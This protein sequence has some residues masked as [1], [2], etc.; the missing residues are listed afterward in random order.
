MCG[1][2]GF[3]D[4]TRN[5]RHGGRAYVAR[6]LERIAYRGPDQRSI[7]EYGSIVLGMNRL[8]IVDHEEHSIPYE[9]PMGHGALVYNGEIYNHQEIR[10]GLGEGIEFQTD[11]DAETVLYD[12]LKR[13]FKGLQE[14]NGMYTMA[15]LNRR[16][17]EL[18]LVRDKAGE[19][20]LYYVKTP[21]F[22]AFASEMKCLLDLIHPEPN[23]TLAYRAFE[24]GVGRETLFKGIQQLLPGEMLTLNLEGECRLKDY[25]KLWDRDLEIPDDEKR[26]EE[27]LTALIEDAIL[28]RTRNSV[29][30]FAIF[31]GGGVDSALMA[32]ISKPDRLYYC[33]YD[34]GAAFDELDYARLVAKKID[35]ELVVVE[36][37]KEDFERTRDRIA[38]HL[39]TPC[40]WTSFSL[41]MLL[42]SLD[43]DIRVIM[44]GE[45][46]D[47]AFAGYHRYHLLHHDEQ[48]HSLDAMKEYQYLI[49][50]YYGS[51]EERYVRLINPCDNVYDQEV[52]QYLHEVV[53]GYFENAGGDVVHGMGMND[54]YSTMQVLLQMSDRLSMAF[55][56]ENRSPFLD[57]RLL[58]YAFR[59]PS[60]YKIREGRTKWILKKISRKIIPHEIADRID[61]RGFSAPLNVWFGWEKLGKYNRA[62]YRNLCFQDWCTNFGMTTGGADVLPYMQPGLEALG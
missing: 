18:T 53:R 36:P 28:L 43:K 26:I 10:S 4:L 54:F 42:E 22:F 7:G 38:Y 8:S 40:T 49:Q 52:M 13:G 34:L 25:W 51:P 2:V 46:A 61:K 57:H 3:V 14:Y 20:P 55:S 1:I 44:T 47:E 19:K 41:W 45:G 32:C 23:I 39:D 33:H 29:H 11:S 56:I 5:P 62:T 31:T 30:Q 24:F 48:I 17:K 59:M 16:R 50:K 6:M 12:F 60:S 9:D 35:R 21:Q 37:K 58:E 27:D 15:F